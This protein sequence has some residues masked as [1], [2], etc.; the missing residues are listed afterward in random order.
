V[1]Y[2]NVLILNG[3]AGSLTVA[4]SSLDLNIVASIEDHAYGLDTQSLN[5]PSLTYVP[6]LPWPDPGVDLQDTLVIAHPPCAAFSAQNN[7]ANKGTEST[8]FE[9]T[10]RVLGYSALHGAA[11]VL[12]ESVTGAYLG[13]KDWYDSWSSYNNYDIYRVLQNAVTY[14][15]PQW[16]PRYWTILIKKGLLK[17]PYLIL[18]HIRKYT[19]LGEALGDGIDEP[20]NPYTVRYWERQLEGLRAGG[21][22]EEQ[23]KRMLEEET[24]HL[25]RI[26]ARLHDLSI[27]Q[28]KARFHISSFDSHVFSILNPQGFSHTVMCVSN[29]VYKGRPVTVPELNIIAGFPADY[30]FAK[31]RDQKCYLS[32]GVAPPVAAWL[33]NEVRLNL[34]GE[35]D[36]GHQPNERVYI[37]KSGEVADLRIKHDEVGVDLFD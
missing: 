17:L 34:L 6:S 7:S 9:C 13:A 37:L 16:R 35:K 29:W 11:A 30:K 12:I 2:E 1:A 10:A 36:L 22:T 18:H 31:I 32:K 19:T 3:Y 23:I 24:G 20:V 25:A 4:A 14:G 28:A 33:L 8:H 5:F 27:H 21:L 26:L 15:V